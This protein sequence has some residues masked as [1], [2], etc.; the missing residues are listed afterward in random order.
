ML[1]QGY[2]WASSKEISPFGPAVWQALGNIYSNV[3]FY[4]T[5]K[6]Y[7]NSPFKCKQISCRIYSTYTVVKSLLQVKFPANEKFREKMR[8][9]SVAYCKLFRENK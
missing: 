3:M 1:P 9:C 5:K 7:A 2:P 8:K 4:N 6:I